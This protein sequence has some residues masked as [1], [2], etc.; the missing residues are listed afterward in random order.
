MVYK[1][2]SE[3]TGTENKDTKR[4]EARKYFFAVSVRLLFNLRLDL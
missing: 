2:I 4:R 3:K 1:A